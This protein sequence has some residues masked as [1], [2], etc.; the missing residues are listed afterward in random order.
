MYSFSVFFI[1]A[2]STSED[3]R[4]APRPHEP[5]QSAP[6]RDDAPVHEHDATAKTAR[7]KGLLGTEA[8]MYK[9]LPKKSLKTQEPKL[10]LDAI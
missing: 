2:T 3:P 5:P 7:E 9:L 6:P 8:T 1:E 4:P 10:A